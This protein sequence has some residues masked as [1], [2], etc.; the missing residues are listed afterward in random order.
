M[1]PK[2]FLKPNI[3]NMVGE[4]IENLIDKS[5]QRKKSAYHW[6]T[7]LFSSF[8]LIIL[9]YFKTHYKKFARTPGHSSLTDS[10]TRH[11]RMFL[12][13]FVSKEENK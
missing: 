4:L 8:E 7:E 13:N 2:V 11:L 3:A 1:I 12:D 6:N 9:L 10:R 5:I